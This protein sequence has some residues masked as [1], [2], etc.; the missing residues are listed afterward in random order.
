VNASSPAI[1]RV[2]RSR[3][4]TWARLVEIWRYREL[5]FGMVRKELKV[6]YKNSILGFFWTLLNPA[7][8]LVVFWLVFTK[9]LGSGLPQF[10]LFFLS[11]LL[12]W[13]LFSIS[14]STA[15]GS[16]VGAAGIVKKVYFPREILP[17]S[18]VGAGLVNFCLQGIVLLVALVA[19]RHQIDWQLAWLLIP[20]LLTVTVFA[21]AL[22]ILLSAINVYLRDTQHLLELA[23]LVWFWMTPVVYPYMMV[24]KR[25]A[26]YVSLYN[27]NPVLPIV[28]TF[29]RVLYNRTSF[30]DGA[31]N[32][33]QI[34]PA[35]AGVWW[36]AR[37]L[38]FALFGSLVLGFVAFLVFDRAEGNFAEEL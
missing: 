32:V 8:Y 28:L 3:R 22:G 27:L 31:G 21:S 11:G 29:Q 15:T 10:P 13:N 26:W 17:L 18:A 36:Y 9:F 24:A 6:K 7:L 30:V 20:A 14:V 37:G 16:V 35:D 25:T 23:L 12:I 33:Q 38:G 5:L 34:L 1:T 4:G 2:I 19:F